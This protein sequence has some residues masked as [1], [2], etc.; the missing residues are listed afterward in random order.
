M[1]KVLYYLLRALALILVAISLN[2]LLVH[3]MPGDPLLHILGEEEYFTLY[4]NY[5]EILDKVRAQYALGGSL[6]EQ[7]IRFLWNT[8]TF[9]FGKSYISG[10]NVVQVVLFRLRWTLVLSVTAIILSAFVGGA[11]GIFAGYHKGGRA[12]SALT[13]VFLLFETIPANCLAL[14]VLVIFAFNLHWFPVGGM[15]SGGLTG[16]AKFADTLY[17]MVLPVSVLALFKT[18]TN[19]LM[20]KSFVSQIRDEEYILTAEA[21]GLPRHKVLFRHV[22]RNVA[23]PY[24]TLL[25]MQ[26]GYMLAGSMLIEVVFSWKGLGTLIY[27]GVIQHDYPTVQLCFLLIAVCVIFF[28]FIADILAWKFDPR[29]KDGAVIHEA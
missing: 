13:F 11:L 15:A 2:F 22:L 6:F 3:L 23:V 10:Q 4:Y 16:W 8:V 5:P 29:I 28:Q 27:D 24:V 26:F 17:H 12:D 19:F 20:M 25:C 21:K 7:Y 9:Q 1:R 18:S 14:I